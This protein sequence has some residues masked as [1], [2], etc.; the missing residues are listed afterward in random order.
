MVGNLDRTA[1]VSDRIS[2]QS[3]VEARIPGPV[4][5]PVVNARGSDAD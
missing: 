5:D 4:F 1:S 3:R 2:V